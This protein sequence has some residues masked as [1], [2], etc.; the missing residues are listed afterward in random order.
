MTLH[1]AL[2][3]LR[4]LQRKLCR[5]TDCRLSE[6]IIDHHIGWDKN[7]HIEVFSGEGT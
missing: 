2:D 4:K 5:K 1:T 3:V 7:S 6:R